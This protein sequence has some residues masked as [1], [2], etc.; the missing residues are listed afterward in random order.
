MTQTADIAIDGAPAGFQ[1]Y[2]RLL[3]RRLLLTICLGLL[4]ALLFGV[5]L[6]SGPSS[7][8]A[9][10]TIAGL[11]DGSTLD[12]G[13]LVIIRE[14]RFPQAAMAV[15]VGMALAL[16][17]GELQTVLD[18][19][20]A[21]P[22]TLGVAS[23]ASFGAALGIVLGVSLPGIAP[24]WMV[25]VDA[26]V[27]SLASMGLLQV[28]TRVRGAGSEATILIGTAL[29][30]S[31]NAL[32][33][34]T[35]F[36][37]SAQAVQQVVFWTLGSLSRSDG[38][39]VAILAFVTLAVLPFS[40]LASWRLTALRLGE[41]RARSFGIDVSRL[42]ALSLVRVSLLTATAISFV[43]TIAFVGLVGPHIARLLIGEDHRFF[44]PA[45]ALSGAAV[46]SAAS[47]A[48]KVVMP[49]VVLPLGVVTAL[50]GVPIYIALIMARR[51]RP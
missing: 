51:T 32:L 37:G 18:N 29:F 44:L 28:L 48:S 4:A 25:S 35:Q 36:L 33:A 50:V 46:M 22:F 2:R 6:V 24:E 38:D 16:S 43:G 41:D 3:R 5:D 9:W 34:L 8:T 49:G 7:L 12:A 17:G 40:L 21:S 15:L 31:F 10:Q 11:F 30:F 13:Q 39:R 42:R 1:A 19:P 45:S 47:I 27:F 23:A 20:L 26:F 14:I